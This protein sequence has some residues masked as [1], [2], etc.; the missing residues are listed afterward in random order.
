MKFRLRDYM[1]PIGVMRYQHLMAK[2]PFWP[3][4]KLADWIRV[5]RRELAVHAARTVPHYA[6]SLAAAGVQPERLDD[7]AEWLRVPTIDKSVVVADPTRFV[8]SAVPRGSVWASTSGSTGMPMKILLEP[9]I[10]AAAFA[11]FWRAWST[12]GYWKLGQR[13]AVMKGPLSDGLLSHNRRMRA[14]ET[15]AARINPSTVRQV[16]DTLA[17]YKPR[18]MRGYPSSMY[19][20]ARLLEE[21]GLDLHIPLVVSGSETLYDYHRATIESVLKARV[22]NH[23]THWER[24]ASILECE[25]GSMHAQEDFGHH[26]LLDRDGRPVPSGV[27]GEITVTG[28]HNRAMP[29]IRYRTGDIGVWADKACTCG[30]TFPVIERI[31]GREVDFLVRKDGAVLA[32]MA[33]TRFMRMLTDVRYVQ[34]VQY[35]AGAVTVKVVRA[36][37]YSEITTKRIVRELR[38]MF[39]E[40]MDVEVEF[41]EIDGLERS[42]VGKIRQYISRINRNPTQP[43]AVV[44]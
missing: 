8:P 43:K 12:G 2:A 31:L 24:S 39:D 25:H 29:F 26:E 3:G 30:R 5:R 4:P 7:D 9:N 22:I 17:A 35:V 23:Y 19:L 34:I 20:F 21:H 1:Q 28:L 36:A 18:F 11:L 41:C 44:G 37:N 14:I 15:V 40:Q 16:R 32:G 33:V 27:E 42:P 10:N 13:H 38:L 6:E